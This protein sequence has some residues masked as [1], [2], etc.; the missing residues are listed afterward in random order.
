MS[1]VFSEYNIVGENNGVAYIVNTLS[2]ALIRLDKETY[3]AL[4]LQNMDILSEQQQTTLKNCGMLID[5]NI[6]EKR[7]MRAAYSAYCH[8]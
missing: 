2:G 8:G 5:E 3:E 6:D 1:Y 7:V 4:K